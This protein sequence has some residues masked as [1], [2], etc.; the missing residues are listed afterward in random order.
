MR[1]E[2]ETRNWGEEEAAG[3][4]LSKITKETFIPFLKEHYYISLYTNWN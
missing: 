3:E 1:E 2:E 4:S